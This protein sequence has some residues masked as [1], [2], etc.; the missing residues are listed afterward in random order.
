MDKDIRWDFEVSN[1]RKEVWNVELQMLIVVQKICRRYNLKYYAIAGTLL[2]AIRHKGFIPWDD[3]L[4]I[5]MPRKDYQKFLEYAK[6]ELPSN[7]ILQTPWTDEDYFQGHA[8]IRMKDTTAI[9][10]IQW[11]DQ[12]KFNQGIFIDIFPL[13]NIPD[14][15]LLRKIHR[16]ITMRTINRINMGRY[17]YTNAEHTEND[18]KLHQK[19][20]TKYHDDKAAL[21]T[22]AFYDKWCAI[23]NRMNTKKWG[24]LSAFYYR[25][26]IFSWDRKYFDDV[27]EMDFEDYKIACPSA[28]DAI[29]TENYGDYMKPVKGSSQHG[30]IFFDTQKSYLFYIDKFD[31]YGSC[32]NNYI[33]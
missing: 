12:F 18:K 8:K 22:L 21:K 16:Y 23:F 11:K 4:D 10:Q 6:K 13:D 32:D 15:A 24:M 17:Y 2:G 1:K 19:M 7:C 31:E 9:R 27:I 3:D 28:Y 29:L 20:K 33:L 25:D 5:A 30:D 26:D 14:N